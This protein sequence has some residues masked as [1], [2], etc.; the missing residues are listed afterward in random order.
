MYPARAT[1]GAI[2]TI[3]AC[4]NKQMHQWDE[5]NAVMQAL[6]NQLIAA[7]DDAYLQ[8]VKDP[9][10]K[11][12]NL[13][14]LQ[15]LEHLYENYDKINEDQKA[16][17]IERMKEPYDITTPIELFFQ[18]IQECIDFASAAQSPLSAEQILDFVFLTLQHTGVFTTEC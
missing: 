1:S 8:G 6:K 10:T 16:K 13:T 5:Y 12:H 2:V 14:V 18:C 7:V 3:K 4:H 9:D 11:Y 15:M 17:N